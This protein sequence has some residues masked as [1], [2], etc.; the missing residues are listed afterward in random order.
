M[1]ERQID[2]LSEVLVT[3]G[4]YGSLYNALSGF[5]EKDDEVIIIE[6]FFD[7]Y[8]PMSVLAEAKCKYIPLRPNKKESSDSSLV[9]SADWCWDEDELSSAF[10]SKTKVII[11]NS[12]NN[13]LGFIAILLQNWF[14]NKFN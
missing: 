4:A 12:P 7:C 5:L 11:I 10:N 3:V 9:T 2:P 14:K 13:P 1:L 6:P 8:A